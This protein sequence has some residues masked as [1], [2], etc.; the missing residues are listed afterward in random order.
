MYLLCMPAHHP[1]PHPHTHP[2]TWSEVV[3]IVGTSISCRVRCR[4]YQRLGSA[5]SASATSPYPW[6]V[7]LAAWL[8]ELRCLGPGWTDASERYGRESSYGTAHL[9]GSVSPDTRLH[10]PPL[11]RRYLAIVRRGRIR[12]G[13]FV[14]R[15][16]DGWVAGGAHCG[17]HA[18]D[19]E[20]QK[21]GNQGSI[22][23][24]GGRF[25]GGLV[26]TR[27]NMVDQLTW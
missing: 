2:P 26:T 23:S 7:K 6:P 19:W 8:D 18:E 25:V 1:H 24:R 16:A 11:A 4:G 20:N 21:W 10:S 5:A 9:Y 12:R 27:Q 15:Q 22:A 13:H 17:T 3:P 14:S